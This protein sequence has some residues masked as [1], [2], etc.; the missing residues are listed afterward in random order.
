MAQAPD[1]P[2]G[3]R[4]SVLITGAA[5]YVGSLVSDTLAGDPRS[6]STIV[7][8][9]VRPV[10]SEQRHGNVHYETLDITDRAALSALLQRHA[11]DTVVHLAAIVTPRPGD[12]RELQYAV[13]VGG[14]ENV[15]AA[16][17]DAGVKK[18]VY[19]SSGA[20]YGYHADNPPLLR[21]DDALRG[22]R[23]F[24]YAWHKRLV[25]ELLARYRHNHPELEQLCFRVSTVLGPSVHNQITAMFERPVV[26]LRE[27]DTPFCFVWDQDVVAAICHGVHGAQT[28]T[29]NLTGDGV[30]TLREVA[31]AM[32]RRFLA[33]PAKALE[34]GLEL[35]SL[36]GKSPYGPEQVAFLRHRPVL[37]NDALKQAG[38][39][40]LPRK[41]SREV[42]DLYRQSREVAHP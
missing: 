16:A 36:T 3:E 18:L 26:G 33:L 21:E 8:A 19:T 20:A 2:Q 41:T 9:D 17:V 5:G 28:G 29:F 37:A 23:A 34:R 38:F 22:N 32:K 1:T 10:A 12:T 39:G 40:S 30:V 27:A 11:I 14:T 31:H 42:F 25:E 7:A 4:R 6:L 15:L 35:L 13:D 24:A